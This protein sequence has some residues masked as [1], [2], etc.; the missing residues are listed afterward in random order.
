MLPLSNRRLNMESENLFC[1]EQPF[2]FKKY[3]RLDRIDH[4]KRCYKCNTIDTLLIFYYECII[5]QP[6]ITINLVQ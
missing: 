6:L 4:T 5:K 1:N 2:A 3:Y